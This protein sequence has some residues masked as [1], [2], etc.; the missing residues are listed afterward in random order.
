MGEARPGDPAVLTASAAKF[1]QVGEGWRQ[2][3]LDHMIQH[4][5]NWYVRK[6]T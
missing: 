1:G 5:W 4:A 6:D 2:F 3:E